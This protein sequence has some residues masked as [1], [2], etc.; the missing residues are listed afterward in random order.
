M[1]ISM[2][3]LREKEFLKLSPKISVFEVKANQDSLEYNQTKITMR[4]KY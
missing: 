2:Q 3:G 1:I 4:I